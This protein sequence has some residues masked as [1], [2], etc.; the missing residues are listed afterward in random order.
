MK[1]WLLNKETTM[2]IPSFTGTPGQPHE[3]TADPLAG[4]EIEQTFF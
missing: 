4:V 2:A 1:Q 3:E